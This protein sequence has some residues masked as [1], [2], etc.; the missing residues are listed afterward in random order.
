MVKA[1]ELIAAGAFLST[2]EKL[3]NESAVDNISAR[4]YR[5]PALGDRPVVRLTADNLAEGEDLTLE[6]LGFTPPEVI[7]PV[8]RR[9]RQALGFPG[10]ALVN[11]PKHARY[12]LELVKGFK[13]AVRRSKAKPGH[14]YDEFVETSKQLGS[15]VAHFLPSF[16]EQVGR[17]FIAFDNSTY[18]SRAFGKAREAEKVHALKVDESTRQDAF[19]EFALAG[20]VSIKALT[21]YGKELLSTHDPKAAWAFFRE[22][23]VRRILGGMPPWPAMLK[24]LQPLMKAAELD[25]EHEIQVILAEVIDSPAISRAAMGFWDSASKAIAQLV[26]KNDH[27]AGVL[28]SMIPQTA[29][30]GK[31]DIWPWLE[32]LESWGILANAWKPGVADEA[33]PSGG[34]A[35]W[36]SRIIQS[37]NRPRQ[38]IF[39]LLEHLAPVLKKD[40]VPVNLYPKPGWRGR[41]V[42][43]ADVLDLALELG[44]PV[45]DPSSQTTFDLEDWATPADAEKGARNRPRDPVHLVADKRFGPLI[46]TAVQEAAGDSNFELAATGKQGLQQARRDWLAAHVAGVSNAALPRAEASL[47]ALDQ[48]TQ[49]AIFREFPDQLALLRQADL[50]SAVTRTIAGGLIDEY[51]WPALESVYESFVAAGQRPPRF[52]GH[53]PYLIVTDSLKAVVLRA[54]QIVFEAELKLPKGHKLEYLM[55]LD[56]DLLVWAAANY[57]MTNFW[58]SD[59]QSGQS[60]YAYFSS[61]IFGIALEMAGGG[62]LIGEKLVHRGDREV[63]SLAASEAIVSDGKHWWSQVQKYD[64]TTYESTISTHEFDPVA[65]KRGRQ[66]MPSFFEDFLQDDA[67]LNHSRSSLLPLG[68]LFSS[69]LFGSQDGLLG[70]RVR[71]NATGLHRIEGIDGR[72]IEVPHAAQFTGLLHQAGTDAYLPVESMGLHSSDAGFRLWDSTGEMELSVISNGSGYSSG[73]VGLLPPIFLN[74]FQFRDLAASKKLRAI[75]KKQTQT[76]L[77]A[78]EQDY[79][80]FKSGKLTTPQSDPQSPPSTQRDPSIHCPSLDAAIDKLLGAG[81]HPRLLKGLRGV[82]IQA[83]QTSRQFAKIVA[84]RSAESDSNSVDGSLTEAEI[85][86]EPFLATL[87]YGFERLPDVSFLSSIEHVSRFFNGELSSVHFPE[88]WFDHLRA[89]S[90][91]LPQRLWSEYCTD[92]NDKKW[93]P[94]AEIWSDLPFQNLPG[95]FRR[96]DG[97]ST[98]EKFMEAEYAALNAIRSLEDEN[99]DDD[100]DDDE[101][102]EWSWVVPYAGRSSRFLIRKSYGD[103]EVLEYSPDGNFESIPDLTEQPHTVSVSPPAIWTGKELRT[104]AQLAQANPINI[105]A[106]D[107]LNSVAS[108]VKASVAEVALVWF[109]L[110]NIDNYSANFMPAHLRDACKLKAKE[111]SAAK[112]SLQAMPPAKLRNLVQAVLTG[113]PAELWEAPPAKVAARLT[114]AWKDDQNQRIPLSPEWVEKLTDAMGYG[115][116]KSRLLEALNSPLNSSLFSHQGNWSFGMKDDNVQLVC[117]DNGCEFGEVVLTAALPSVALLIYG[118]PVGDPAREKASDVIPALKRALANPGLLLTAGAHYEYEPKKKTAYEKLVQSSVGQLKPHETFQMVDD[119]VVVVVNDSQWFRVAFRPAAL[120]TTAQWERLANQLG[121]LIAGQ[122]DDDDEADGDSIQLINQLRLIHSTE[123][124]ELGKRVRETPV[125][126]GSYETNPLLSVPELVQQVAKKLKVSENAAAYYL[127]LLALPDPTDKNIT[128]W[129]GWTTAALKKIAQELIEKKVVLEATRSRAGRKFFLPGGWEDLKSPHLPLET[130]K[131]PLFQMTRDAYQRATPP[132]GRVLP[133]QPVSMLFAKAWKR[134]VDGDVPRYEEV[135]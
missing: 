8:A 27:V 85:A 133:L 130:W 101:D 17:E 91:G 77:D 14:G 12:A 80:A 127:Q 9:Q 103:F 128:V 134:I 64:M 49:R 93:I 53:F 115:I 60:G 18:A 68:E 104:F 57:Q 129:N 82:V 124:E 22:L 25:Q 31:E 59:P 55:Y 50:V 120:K 73:Q 92:P 72:S 58:N 135:K 70:Y 66:S 121:A 19:L 7:G 28:L 119:G 78:E 37:F 35:A 108:E 32:H 45:S 87:S 117:D 67:T 100:D 10:W 44:I 75:T 42:A 1:D 74:A 3:S 40:N 132:L 131:M 63:M 111:C 61:Q 29:G 79:E 105:P 123:F 52:F 11:D 114:A 24:D 65:G 118:L 34:A 94:F 13:K 4:V 99:D 38:R 41:V 56:G 48:K 30:W 98:D 76:L 122:S 95:R 54:D 47:L 81:V 107:L 2:K 84:Q 71:S 33:R 106:V 15:S 88:V 69:S 125:P 113:D 96:F 16:W 43:D 97:E 102:E 109:G 23:C 112:K 46:R 116:V 90:E 6:F 5:H 39:D 20:A 21:E 83:G 62:T 89:L 51:G 86:V 110:P 26:K 36:L 126:A